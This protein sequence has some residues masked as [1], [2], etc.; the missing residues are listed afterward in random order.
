MK[1][2]ENPIE[3]FLTRTAISDEAAIY[4]RLFVLS[5][6]ILPLAWLSFFLFKRFLTT[7]VYKWV[8]KSSFTWDD[9]LADRRVLNNLAHIAPAFIVRMVA[10]T[11][12]VDFPQWHTLVTKLTD[13]YFTLAI[14]TIVLGLLKVVE[15]ALS[16]QPAFKDKPMMSYFQL[17]RL[18]LYIVI[19][20]LL[21]SIL[22]DQDP[23]YFLGAFGTMTAILLLIFKDTILGLVA[24]MQISANDMVRVGDWVEMPKFNADGDVLA[25]NLN[26]V[27]VQNWDKTITTIP[28][29]YFITDSFKNWRGMVESGGRRIKR[30]ILL[31]SQTIRFV[32]KESRNRYK[33]YQLISDYIDARQKEIEDFN[34]EQQI[35]TSVLINGRRMTNLGVFRKYIEYYLRNHPFIR[36]DMTIL[37]RQ[38]GI[39]DKGVPIEVYCFTTTTSW[40][41][42]EDIQ[43]DVFDHLLAAASF[44]GLEIFQQ[45]SGKDI[46]AS[47]ERF[48]DNFRASGGS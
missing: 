5:L 40:V 41:A 29:Y 12:F 4:V 8:K 10:P 48:A 9:A 27:K 25:I 2:I 30:S 39:E 18:I 11:L 3:A 20:I 28:T 44:F 46:S 32:D 26:T 43:A 47:I 24:S 36:K 42:Y 34:A 13:C 7:Y 16:R 33:Q 35:D 6:L 31:N 21:L 22:L 17:I 37:V 38:L 19:F 1:L 23:I 14:F 15:Y 45:P